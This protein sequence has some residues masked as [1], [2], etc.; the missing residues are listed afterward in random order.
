M[1]EFLLWKIKWHSEINWE[2]KNGYSYKNR[3]KDKVL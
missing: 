2:V 1:N 3:H